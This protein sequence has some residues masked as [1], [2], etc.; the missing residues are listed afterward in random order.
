MRT[1][2]T[3]K[4]LNLTK[5]IRAVSGGTG[6]SKTYSILMI[7]ID[8]AG[9]LKNQTIDVISESYPHLEHRAIK[10][11]KEIMLTNGYWKDELWNDTKHLFTFETGS[12]IAFLSM[13]K[14]GKAHGPRR[15]V[16]FINECNYLPYNIVDQLITR[17]RK[18]VWMDWN[19][20]SEFWF[21]TEMLNHRQ[22]IDFITLT[23]LDNGALSKEELEEIMAHKGNPR[24]WRVYG[25]GLLGET[26]GRV[27]QGWQI[28]NDIPHEAR[29]ERYGLDFGYNPDPAAIVALYYYNGGYILDEILY[30][31]G[32]QNPELAST[33]K[34]HPPALVIADSA[35]PKS[36]AEIRMFGIN[37]AGTEK[38]A[39]SVRYGVK[40]LQDQRISV[41]TRSL[42]LLKE[43]RN[44]FQKQ[45][46]LTNAFII[47]Q[48]EGECH[49]LDA[50]RYAVCSLITVKKRQELRKEIGK[51]IWMNQPQT[52]PI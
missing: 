29:L 17:T 48:Y 4:L 45:D 36:I 50:S 10:D 13:D 31:R 33:L 16:L 52:N 40:T 9:A 11:F 26:E 30:Q 42:N 38:G 6:A 46:R 2:A 44:F 32:V 43:Y 47:G 25:E 22:D 23:F 3:E 19:P 5:K 28:I 27:Y 51:N 20:V 34:N 39:D 1:Q 12:T 41:T 37:I 15:D 49:L 14:L 8:Y 35:E 18:I 7:L 21:Y 24:W